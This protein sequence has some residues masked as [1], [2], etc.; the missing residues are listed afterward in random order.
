MK[1]LNSVEWAKAR[2][3]AAELAAS[4]FVIQPSDA[5]RARATSLVDLYD[6]RAADALHLAAALEWSAGIPRGEKFFATDRK[7]QEAAILTG[8]EVE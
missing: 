1:E 4:W 5:L 8:F 6:L 2:K 3:L 7:L